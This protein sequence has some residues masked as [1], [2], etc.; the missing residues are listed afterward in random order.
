MGRIIFLWNLSRAFA[1]WAHTANVMNSRKILAC[2][3]GGIMFNRHLAA[4]M[5]HWRVVVAEG[6]I[7]Y[8]KVRAGLVFWM[9][10]ELKLGLWQWQRAYVLRN[11]MHRAIV[12]ILLNQ[13]LAALSWWRHQSHEIGSSHSKMCKASGASLPDPKPN[14]YPNSYLTRTLT[15]T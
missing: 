11:I 2:Y 1:N 13:L 14:P 15:R 8:Q 10:L 9:N 12:G 6:E 5:R 4:A 3:V 7:K